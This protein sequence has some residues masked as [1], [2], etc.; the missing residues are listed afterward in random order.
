MRPRQISL[1]GIPRIGRATCIGALVGALVVALPVAALLGYVGGG[2]TGIVAAVQVG[3][4]GGMGFGGMLG[5][6]I[7][8][9]HFE[10]SRPDQPASV[11]WSVGRWS[12]SDGVSANAASQ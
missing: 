4:F 10:R 7:K 11:A 6:V 1:T 2:L 9:D 12:K 5:A 3:F 8:A